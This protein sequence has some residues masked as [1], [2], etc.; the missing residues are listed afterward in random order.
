MWSVIVVFV[1]VVAAMGRIAFGIVFDVVARH[2]R[3]GAQ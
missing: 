2:I 1:C 3:R